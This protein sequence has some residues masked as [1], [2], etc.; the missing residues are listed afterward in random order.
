M[1]EVRRA[2]LALVVLAL[3]AP[4]AAHAQAPLPPVP[5]PVPLA[6]PAPSVALGKPWRGR[7]LG[8]VQLPASGLGF[9][10][11]DAV[12]GR[13]PDRPW[14]QWG[15]GAL[16]ALLER[17]ALEVRLAHPDAAPLLFE[18]LSRPHGGPFDE[19]WGG[20]GHSS[21]QNGLD[22]DVAYPRLDGR[23]RA[24]SAPW[25]VDRV[26]AQELVDRFVLAGAERVFVGPHVRLRGPRRV[27]QVLA[28]HDDHLHVRIPNPAAG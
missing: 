23:W 2:A 25:Q 4:A 6:V 14:R 10:T 3:A 20:L 26:L 16:V 21:H 7:L 28:H 18:D 27:V 17:V 12:L 1:C 19:R 9:R 24:P 13:R 8:G 22:A 11:W 5:P 15:T